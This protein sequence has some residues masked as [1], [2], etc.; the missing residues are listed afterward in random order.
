[1]KALIYNTFGGPEV[2]EYHDMPN[3]VIDP[4]E[5]L[6]R[7][8]AIG[9]NFADVYRR[10]GNYHLEG[11]PPYILGY[12]GAGI[13]EQVG[14]DIQ[15]IQKGDRI[16]FADVPF[17]NAELVAVPMDK[18]IPLP[19]SISFEEASSVLL[20]G[21]TAHYLTKDSYSVNK[22]D[23][24]LVHA[25]AGGV[26][27]LLI[28]IAKLLGGK[29]I[30][31]TSSEKKAKA[32]KDAGADVVFLY[33]DDWKSAVLNETHGKGVDVVYESVG[34][35]LMDSFA[36]T[37]VGGTVV[38][39]GMA[40]GDP[41]SVD[42]RML[43]DTS[44]TLTGGDLWNVLTSREERVARSGELFRWMEEGKVKLA[45]PTTF[46]LHEGQEAHRYLESRQSTGKI[47][48]IP[49]NGESK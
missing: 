26:G 13:V 31:L 46:A 9:L 20:Q 12:E 4:N 48:L 5:I 38:F 47:L 19:E 11:E 22:N 17:A 2:L 27:Q 32:A 49:S 33:K 29:V 21:L 1:M 39:Y 18:A 14:A 30:G 42:P 41:V 7:M 3:P 44:K 16:A 23:V 8:K 45:K 34:S 25:A 28:Q 15:G 43:M 36:A 10:K 6:I 35:T 40:G 24:V 37:R